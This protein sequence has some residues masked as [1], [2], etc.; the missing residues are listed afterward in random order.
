MV[1]VNGKNMLTIEEAA[2]K[3]GWSKTRLYTKMHEIDGFPL[4]NIAGRYLV[5]RLDLKRW[6]DENADTVSEFAVRYRKTPTS[7]KTDTNDT[8][9]SETATR[10]YAIPEPELYLKMSIN[11][12]LLSAALIVNGKELEHSTSF[13]RD[14]IEDAE[15]KI[16]QAVSY[17]AHSIF[18]RVQADAVYRGAE[19]MKYQK[20]NGRKEA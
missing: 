9:K 17:V 5:G 1:N 18:K 10:G 19:P 6:M 14:D 12:D 20:F 16:A 3:L 13:V 8:P 15:L 7:S 4:V 11:G 2:E